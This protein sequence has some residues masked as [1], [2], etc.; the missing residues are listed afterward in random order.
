[1]KSREKTCELGL[2]RNVKVLKGDALTTDAL[3]VAELNMRKVLM[4]KM[5][6]KMTPGNDY[7]V[8]FE[9][10]IEVD[11]LLVELKCSGMLKEGKK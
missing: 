1:M 5:A 4:A 11:V 9:A 3:T 2:L 6:E 8:R 7:I 10:E